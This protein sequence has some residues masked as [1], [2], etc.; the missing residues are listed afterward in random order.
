MKHNERAQEHGIMKPIYAT[1]TSGVH[2][3]E[4]SPLFEY[5]LL[6]KSMESFIKTSG[7][8]YSITF[9]PIGINILIGNGIETIATEINSFGCKKAIRS[10]IDDCDTH[11]VITLLLPDEN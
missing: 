9:K 11:Y 10:I 5:W 3:L 2:S 4:L 8:I 6:Q 7:T 1:K